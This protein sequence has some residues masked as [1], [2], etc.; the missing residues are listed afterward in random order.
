MKV[1]MLRDD[2]KRK[3][4]LWIT[5]TYASPASIRALIAMLQIAL[6]WMEKKDA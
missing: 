1:G 6:K 3:L 2:G 5:G 4:E